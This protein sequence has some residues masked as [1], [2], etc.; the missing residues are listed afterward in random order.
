MLLPAYINVESLKLLRSRKANS[1]AGKVAALLG[2]LHEVPVDFKAP[3]L[4]G[5]VCL[6][7]W[8]W[9]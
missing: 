9:P 6:A 2:E 1:T 8:A 7:R 5:V 4:E 3:I